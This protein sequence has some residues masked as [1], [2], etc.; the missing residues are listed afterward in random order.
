MS[1][2]VPSSSYAS[3]VEEKIA[4][5]Y[6]AFFNRAADKN[7]LEYWK[8]EAGTLGEAE[9]V[10]TLAFGFAAHP[11]FAALYESLENEQYVEAIYINTLGQAGDAEGIAYWKKLLDDGMT[12]SDMVAEFVSISLDFD[13]NDPQYDALHAEAI[14]GLNTGTFALDR[15]QER[16]DLL[17]N[18]VSVSLK[19]VSLLNEETNLE[20]GTNPSDSDSL[21]LDKKFRASVNVLSCITHEANA[22]VESL[23]SSPLVA[24]DAINRLKVQYGSICQ[25]AS[26]VD[27]IK[28]L[29]ENLKQYNFF[30]ETITSEKTGR[31]W[32][33]RNLGAKQACTSV[34]DE[35]C[36][37]DYY[38][39]GR[40]PDGHEKSDSSISLRVQETYNPNDAKFVIDSADWTT[41][42]SNGASRSTTY[43]ACPVGFRVPS[44]DEIREED[45]S[46]N[47]DLFKLAYAGSR[48]EDG[49]IEDKSLNAFLMSNTPTSLDLYKAVK[50]TGYFE[51]SSIAKR[52]IGTSVRCIQVLEPVAWGVPSSWSSCGGVCGISGGLQTRSVLCKDGNGDT[53]N[54]SYCSEPKP[55]TSQSCETVACE[56]D[57]ISETI[58][59]NG[60]EYDTVISPYT[61]RTWLDRNLGADQ[62]CTSRTDLACFGDYYQWGRNPDGHEKL[63]SLVTYTLAT[64]ISNVGDEFIGNSHADWTTIDA[65]GVLRSA[66]WSKTDGSS[67]CPVGFRVST[68]SELSAE[69]IDENKDTYVEVYEDFLKLPTAGYRNNGNGGHISNLSIFWT[70]TALS[71][72][73]I[74]FSTS[75]SS[76]SDWKGYGFSV[77]C[78]LPVAP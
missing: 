59:H 76:Q 61:G 72:R 13:R 23:S 45:F 4:G 21:D 46:K 10:K 36:F 66:N 54:D 53:I 14:L 41:L 69:T 47:Q 55:E 50:Y 44:V 8:A 57:F 51:S 19:F 73:G 58:S 62:V 74:Y 68:Y 7:G 6:I 1:T 15:A 32:M 9:A 48:N 60:Y 42:D 77:R 71:F 22:I 11:K 64:G 2:I 26:T 34:D 29:L 43:N 12:R 3:T 28:S 18:K 5:L 20:E 33:D 31:V 65:S 75:S 30:F 56:D 67:V 17:K 16:Q 52:T 49:M 37:G 40:Y 70:S 24:V 39:W 35:G 63:T 38:Q 78:I 25:D 27:T